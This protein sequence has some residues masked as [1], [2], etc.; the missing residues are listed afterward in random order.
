MKPSIPVYDIC[1]ISTGHKQEDLLAERMSHYLKKNYQRVHQQHGHSFFHMVFFTEGSGSQTIDFS[2]YAVTPHQIYFM[3]PGQVHSWHFNPDVDGY[4]IHFSEAFFRTFLL[5]HDYLDRFTFF[6]G[7]SKDQVM[8]VPAGSRKDVTALLEK[9]LDETAQQEYD[10]V[11]VLLLQLFLTI[12]KCCGKDGTK[13][14]PQQKQLVLRNF[15]QLINKHYRN[16]KL[17]KEYAELLYI[18]PN[19][20]NAL[21]Q[22]LL[23]KTAGELIR[24]RIL[25]EAKRMLTNA[26]MTVTQIA[27]EL[28][29]EDNSYFSRFFKKY[30]GIT[31]DE[32]RKNLN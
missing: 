16:I 28:N 25:L 30:E 18:T 2:R 31:P 11:R 13:I 8:T 21:C 23:G 24:D 4:V 9:I 17:P 10:M 7:N 15:Q 27:R 5:D 22:D 29:F 12:E 6:S 14:I 19:H 3:V 26:G 1:S 20:L 32:F